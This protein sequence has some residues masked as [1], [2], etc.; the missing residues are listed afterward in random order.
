MTQP[1][2]KLIDFHSHILPNMD[3][4]SSSVEMSLQMIQM[5][6]QQGVYAI[7]LTPHFYPAKDYPEHFLKKRSRLLNE[8]NAQ[9]PF[10]VPLLI[11]GAEIQ[12]FEGLTSMKELPQMRIQ[13]SP[14]LLIEMP[15]RTW[16]GRMIDDLLE[17][18]HR[19]EYRVILAHIERYL[20]NQKESTICKLVEEGIMMQSNASFFTGAFSKRKALRMLA[21]GRIH[22]L[23]SDCHNMTS[24]PPNLK[25]ACSVITK[26]QGSDAVKNVMNCGFQLLLEEARNESF[27]YSTNEEFVL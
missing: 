8:L 11:L 9:R 25:K 16:T 6:F 1:Y 14:G 12:Y 2:G 19:S 20:D 13:K 18:N 4:G 22:L 3:D 17:L 24:R 15:F 27:S 5:A 21:D 10:P 7:V 23:G 26:K